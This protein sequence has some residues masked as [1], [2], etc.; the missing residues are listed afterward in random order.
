[1]IPIVEFQRTLSRLGLSQVRAAHLLGVDPRTVR[2]WILGERALPVTTAI[3]VGLL[4]AGKI[5]A[6]DIE[7][8][9]DR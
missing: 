5:T 4:G 2:R 3:L 8:L 6:K 9:K 1:M 7:S